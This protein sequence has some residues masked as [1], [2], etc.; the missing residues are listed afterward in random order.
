MY[1]NKPFS[2]FHAFATVAVWSQKKHIMLCSN[3]I[4]PLKSL[5]TVS[6][7]EPYSKY[8]YV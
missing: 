5:N 7:L 3:S 2:Q 8:N 1:Y 4:N 6:H